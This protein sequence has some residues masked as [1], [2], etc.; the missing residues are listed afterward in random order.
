MSA[1]ND[2]MIL[3]IIAL[4]LISNIIFI[5]LFLRAKKKL[6]SPE[7][8]KTE[9]YAFMQDLMNGTGLIKVTRIETSDIFLRSPRA[10]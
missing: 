9:L 2:A 3:L 10:R 6:K 8:D 1:M 7:K 4:L 5:V